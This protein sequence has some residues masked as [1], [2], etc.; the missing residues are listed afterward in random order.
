MSF[1]PPLIVTREEIDF[2]VDTFSTALDQTAEW[3]SARAG[4]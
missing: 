1:S 4:A 2:I 3:A